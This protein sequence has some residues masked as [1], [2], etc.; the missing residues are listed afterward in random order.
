MEAFLTILSWIAI[1][2]FAG[3]FLYSSKFHLGNYLL[4]RKRIKNSEDKISGGVYKHMHEKINWKMLILF[5]VIKLGIIIV[6]L[7]FLL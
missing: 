6:I 5:Q 7:D 2:L 1:I 4:Q 3:S